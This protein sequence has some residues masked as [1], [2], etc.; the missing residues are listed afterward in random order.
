MKPSFQDIVN[1]FELKGRFK[2]ATPY[3]VGHINDTYIADFQINSF[4]H[5][6]ILQR[7]N[8]HVFNNPEGVMDNIKAVTDHLRK[9]IITSGG[10]PRR[11]TL[12]LSVV[13]C[14]WLDAHHTV[15]RALPGSR[16]DSR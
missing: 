7:I 1:H 2:S 4:T 15:L 13:L 9:K 11:E 12:T 3:G 8:H 6:Y 16:R 5:R 14:K 10:D